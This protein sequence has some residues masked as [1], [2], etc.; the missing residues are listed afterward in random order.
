MQEILVKVTA[1]EWAVNMADNLDQL[2]L[3]Q[4]GTLPPELFAQQ[5][6]LNRQ[7]QMAQMLMQQNQQPQGQMISGRYV[8]PSWAQQLAP[9]ANMLTGAYLTKQGDTKAAELAQQLRTGRNAEQ[10][11]IMEALNKGDTKGALG[12][13]TGSQYGAGKEF[14]PALIGSVIPKTPESVA[15]YNAAKADGFKGTYND[16]KNQM[17]P[18][19]KGELSIRG[20]ELNKG[21]VVETPNGVM[22]INPRTGATTPIMS[23]GQPVLGKNPLTESQGKAAVFHSQMVGANNEL[24]NVYASGFNPNKPQAQITTN[25][26]GGMLNFL[27]PASSQQAKQAQNQWTEAYLRFKT[28]AGTNAH[29]IEA[30]RKTYFPDVGDSPAVI[31]QKARMREQAQ[32][33]IAMAAGPQGGKMGAQ[34]TVVAPAPAAP[35]I[36]PNLLQYMTPEQ[37]ALFGGK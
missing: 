8:A 25:M 34:S 19:Q 4:S 17:T 6:Q 18:Y 31:Q 35:K 11:A 23:N 20:A 5:Q 14:I 21:Q 32:N 37:R 28:G 26:A 1:K 13:A 27:T 30:N 3:N 33:D 10:A 29:E 24:N 36:D 9:V 22:L 16:F 12:L 7:Q 15:E 2:N